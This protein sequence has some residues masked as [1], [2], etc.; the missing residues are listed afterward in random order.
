[1]GLG[2][3]VL[4]WRGHVAGKGRGLVADSCV[5]A[6]KRVEIEEV[7]GGRKGDILLYVLTEL[8]R[9]ASQLRIGHF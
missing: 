1:M 3:G 8:M 4:I 6:G 2:V 7:R 9:A 5:F